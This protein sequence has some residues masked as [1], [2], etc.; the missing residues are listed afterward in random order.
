MELKDILESVE[1]V[2]GYKHEP[3]NRTRNNVIIRDLYI[4]L[5]RVHTL[6]SFDKIGKLV[7]LKTSASIGSHKRTSENI[8]FNV[9]GY[10]TI[11][12]NC[13]KEMIN[14][15]GAK[16]ES[17][18]FAEWIDGFGGLEKTKKYFRIST[19]NDLYL[20]FLNVKCNSLE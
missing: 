6:Y 7:G 18:E 8:N 11:L 10:S 13:R 15:T 19:T 12:Q 5:A 2:I 4:Y 20:K 9:N 17:V 16:N 3:N 14:K 1:K